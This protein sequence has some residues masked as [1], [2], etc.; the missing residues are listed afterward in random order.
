VRAQNPAAHTD[1]A[2]RTDLIGLLWVIELFCER[3]AATRAEFGPFFGHGEA[4][5]AIGVHARR[6]EIHHSA[7]IL[8]VVLALFELTTAIGAVHGAR[9]VNGN[10]L[11]GDDQNLSAATPEPLTTPVCGNI[12]GTLTSVTFQYHKYILTLLYWLAHFIAV[13]IERQI[14][15]TQPTAFFAK[16]KVRGALYPD[17]QG[18]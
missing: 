14:K 8:T 4:R 5:C 12:I 16:S 9:D 2:S 3:L 15:K 10:P 1:V 17:S 18:L 7:A 11:F 6:G 13:R